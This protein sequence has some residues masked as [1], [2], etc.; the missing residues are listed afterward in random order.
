[1]KSLLTVLFVL[2]ATTAFS[3]SVITVD[4][5][6][7]DYGCGVVLVD[8]NDFAMQKDLDKMQS[9]YTKLIATA[10]ALAGLELDPGHDGLSIGTSLAVSDFL[11]SDNE[12]AG[13]VGIMYGKDN[14]AVNVKIGTTGHYTSASAGLT[15][16][17]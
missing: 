2:F 12:L 5:P 11:D 10:S 7:G 9:R 13:A 15:Y 6:A 17:F 14:K 4:Q 8:Q 16:A 3:A 1:M